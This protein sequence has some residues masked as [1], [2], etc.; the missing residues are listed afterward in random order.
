MVMSCYGKYV[1]RYFEM[2]SDW[3]SQ[4]TEK[5]SEKYHKTE[6]KILFIHTF[7]YPKVSPTIRNS[8]LESVV[9]AKTDS[10][11]L[12]AELNWPRRPPLW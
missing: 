9:I 2:L 4:L 1:R 6:Q 5:Y 3:E 10:P 12:C 7:T 11:G 8:L